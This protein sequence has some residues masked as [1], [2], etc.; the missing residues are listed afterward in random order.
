MNSK[1]VKPG[2]IGLTRIKGPVGWM[3]W[4]MQA[5]NG[6]LSKW[7]HAFITIN[8]HEVFEAQPGGARITPLSA[9]ADRE[10][11]WLTWDIPDETRNKIAASAFS[12]RGIGYNWTT[13]F[14]LS[15]YRLRLPITTA[16]LKKRVSND[17]RLICSQ[18]VDH[19]YRIHGVHLFTDGRLPYDVTP[20][21]LARLL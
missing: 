9:Y 1:N 13:Y 5:I 7:T 6:D 21:D 4:L 15:A 17:R 14:Y 8:G 11:A 12:M 20:G 19:L 16:I 10:V 3:V 2:T 18:A